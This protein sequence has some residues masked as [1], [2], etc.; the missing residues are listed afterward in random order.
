MK[1][2]PVSKFDW[3]NTPTY[4]VAL[5]IGAVFTAFA[6]ALLFTKRPWVDE[7]WFTGPALDLVTRGKFGTLLLDP[8]GS[9]LRLY[10]SGAFLRG[11]NQRTYWVMPLHLLQLAA[12]GKVFGFSVFSMRMPSV[13]W[14]GIT[15]AGTGF[16]VRR[17]YEGRG[18]ALVAAAVLA[19][20]FGFVNGAPTRGWT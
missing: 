5:L 15:L 13:L 3:R 6:L 18:A 20:D 14:G 1:T 19:V 17:L 10:K 11:I 4:W 7:A 16:A 8:A 9:H 12:W 2:P